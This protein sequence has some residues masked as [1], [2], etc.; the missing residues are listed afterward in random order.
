[1]SEEKKGGLKRRD[2]LKLIGVAGTTA[3]VTGGCSSEPVEQ[4]IPHVIPPDKFIP[5]IP[6]YF[7]STCRE[8]PAGC[9][10]VVKNREG[11]AI[12]IEGNPQSPV[13]KGATCARGQAS[14]QGLY[15]PDRIRS[16]LKFN[17]ERGSMQPVGWA[18]AES[19]LA[20]IIEKLKNEG[21]GDRIVYLS[22]NISGTLKDLVT[23]WLR[24]T[25]GGKHYTYET[26]SHE[27]IR[28]ANE[29]VYDRD[30]IPSYRLDKA[31]FVLSFGADFLETWLSPVTYSKDFS[32]LHTVR[33][34]TMGK[35]VQVEP[36]MSVTASSADQW[37]QIRP[38]SE[39][40]LILGIANVIINNRWAKHNPAILSGLVS[41]FTPEMVAGKT[42]VSEETITELARQFSSSDSIA[43]GGGAAYTGTNATETQVALNILNHIAGNI[44]KTIDFSDWQMLSK[45]NSYE[46]IEDLISSM[47]NGD[48]ELLIIHNTNPVFTLPAELNAAEAISKVPYVVSFSS[49]MDET[50]ELASLV[51]PDN[52]SLESWG[53]YQPRQGYV[54]ITQPVMTT[55]FNTKNTGD[56]LLS[57]SKRIDS[58]EDSFEESDYLEYLRNSWK[59]VAEYV[60]PGED[61]D[62]FWN[63][64]LKNGGIMFVLPEED[65]QLSR[66]V[67]QV[68]F[69]DAEISSE[70][71]MYLITYPSYRFYDGRGANKPWLQELPEALSTSVWDSF[72]EIHPDTAEELGIREGT[73]VEIETDYGK[74]STQAFIFEGIRRD[75]IALP[76]GQGHKSYGRY[77]K[78][79]GVNPVEVL[80]AVK[81][82]MSGAFAW[83]STRADIRNTGRHE[84][85]VRTQY[86]KSQGDRVHAK[87][88]NINELEGY[89]RKD[90]EHLDFYPPREYSTYRWAMAIDL[91]KC[92]GCGACM[93][94]CSAENNIPFVGKD[95]I[96]KRRE[97]SWLRIERY[98]E[99]D[100][101]GNLD[102]RFLP[103]LCQQCGNAP[104]EPVC[105][106]Y[107]TYHNHEGLNGM[108][109]NR[110]VGTR[111]CSNN[112]PYKVRRFNWHSYQVPEPLNWQFNPDVTVRSMGVME[113]CTFC[114]QRIKHAQDSAKDRNDIVREGDLMTACQ[115]ACPT[116]A[117]TFGNLLEENSRVAE[118]SKD[119]RGYGI[120]DKL[121]IQPG[122]TYLKKV[123]WDKV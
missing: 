51:L 1:M 35:V 85:L 37:V 82:S 7:A 77:A 112:C 30:V 26:F 97:M 44:G 4:I 25:G 96:A 11:R 28:K 100:E 45:S 33:D 114:V 3:A 23:K 34:N 36:R 55:V 6:S 57:V 98:F 119:K 75:T 116:G 80:P 92:T 31:D 70:K 118:L 10:I 78:D 84:L 41:E 16:P 24:Y 50:T 113:K 123:K 2:F 22:N 74:L 120:L 91:S 14:L 68:S 109:Y 62:S 110:C 52:V 72:V 39:H 108:I 12:K 59:S 83:L 19:E 79:R 43:I 29:I 122:I 53:D 38:G 73:Y 111:Y 54:G 9:G 46:E 5:G 64:T 103:M 66:E 94:A 60:S 49:F 93:T 81:D 65:V 90:K 86:T 99:K 104:C 61:F 32:K 105:P 63:E 8:C 17:E 15:N 107:A 76:F 95:Q 47:N 121:N 56:V 42:D 89:V 102:T 48:V 40:Y 106:V 13:S 71:K 58:L 117:I 27:P 69:K 18:Q 115:Q 88:I 101:Q 87:T 67:L 21:K 20:S